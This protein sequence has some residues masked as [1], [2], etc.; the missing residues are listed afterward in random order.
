MFF[1][2]HLLAHTYATKGPTSAASNAANS[3]AVFNATGIR[4]LLL[5]SIQS[6]PPE[7]PGT[8]ES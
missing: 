4:A 7:R 8:L 6:G 1:R 3:N 2:A 5:C